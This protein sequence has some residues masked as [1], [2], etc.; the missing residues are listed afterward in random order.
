LLTKPKDSVL[1][2]I[3]QA[4]TLNKGHV[5]FFYNKQK[6]LL[7]RFYKLCA[8]MQK[9]GYK[10]TISRG[11]AFKGFDEE[12]NQNWQSCPQ[13]DVIV[14]ERIALRISQKPHLYRSSLNLRTL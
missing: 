4:F 1:A 8:E 5:R 13:D 3:P 14:Q 12:F 9:R 6:F 10:H 11:E 7:N 2:N